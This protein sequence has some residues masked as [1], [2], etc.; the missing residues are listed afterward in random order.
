MKFISNIKSAYSADADVNLDR[1]DIVQTILLIAG[2]AIVTIL[3]VNWIGTAIMN[4]GADTAACIESLDTYASGESTGALG[5][6][7]EVDHAADNSFSEDDGYSS[8]Y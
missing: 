3:V 6:C 4:K 2:F 5:E 8:R 7:G 1:G